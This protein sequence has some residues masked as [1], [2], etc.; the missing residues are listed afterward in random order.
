MLLAFETRLA[1]QFDAMTAYGASR[2]DVGI[3]L[4]VLM[5][6]ALSAARVSAV[7]P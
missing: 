1:E 5:D 4:V 2:Y 3:A 6:T 7:S